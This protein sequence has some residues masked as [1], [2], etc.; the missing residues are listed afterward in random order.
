MYTDKITNL[1]SLFYTFFFDFRYGRL[2]K[3]SKFPKNELQNSLDPIVYWFL[4]KINAINVPK[5]YFLLATQV[6]SLSVRL[7]NLFHTESDNTLCFVK[8]VH[9]GTNVFMKSHLNRYAHTWTTAS[10]QKCLFP[11]LRYVA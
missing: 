6:R 3:S 4:I 2:W 11:T 8:Q 7:H 5:N 1:L 9:N 10:G